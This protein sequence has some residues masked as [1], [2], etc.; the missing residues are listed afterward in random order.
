M[1]IERGTST[2]TIDETQLALLTS[3]RIEGRAGTDTINVESLP[4]GYGGTDGADLLIY[5][6]RLPASSSVAQVP[7]DDPFIDHVNFTGSINLNGGFLDVWADRITVA[8]GT[9][10]NPIIIET[11]NND[12]CFRA[13]LLGIA[14]L[15]N[16]V[17]LGFGTD[18]MVD[19]TIGTYAQLKGYGLWLFSQAEDKSIADTIGATKEIENFVIEPLTGWLGE[20]LALPIK[21]LV[22]NCTANV[23]F[24]EGAQLI[25]TGPIGIYATAAADASS[26]AK[27]SLFSIGYAQAN[28]SADITIETGVLIQAAEAVVITSTGEAKA[29]M[30]VETE[31]KA[32]STPSPGGAGAQFALSLGVSYANIYSHVTM[33]QGATVTAGRTANLTAKGK[34]ESEAEAESGLF[35]DGK[36]GLAFALEF[37]KADVETTV[38]G[39]VIALC[40][41]V[42]G[43]TV[44]IEIDPTVSAA[45]FKSNQT[46]VNLFRGNTVQLVADEDGFA[47][48]TVMKYRG[49]YLESADLSAQVYNSDLWEETTPNIGYV[50]YAND[51]IYVGPNALVT[52]DTVT[53]TRR[54]GVNIGNLVDGREYYVVT[55]GDGWITLTES[56]INALR[57]A[58]GEDWWAVDLFEGMGTANNQKSFTAAEVN[59]A[60]DT[61]TLNRDDPVFNT[62][63]LGQAVVFQAGDGCSI[64]GLTSGNTYYV[65]ASTTEQNIQGDSRFASK[66]IIRLAELENEARA[67]VF[68]D[69]GTATGSDFKLIA[70]HVL[71]SGFAT[72]VG[73]VA[74]LEAE[75][76]CSAKAGLK[77]EDTD[78]PSKWEKFKDFVG[79]NVTDAILQKATESYRTNAAKPGA[80]ASGSIAVSGALAFS[81]ADHDVTTNVGDHAV[82]KSN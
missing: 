43:Y 68:I 16:M 13:R 8:D 48:G 61:I 21:V 69:L 23:T 65:V 75:T 57:V 18:R 52:E 62:F 44:K 26:V 80:G 60:D 63:E 76:K 10:Q 25:A 51:R 22:K 38:D 3:L 19:I 42:G 35:S 20:M 58:A 30:K 39:T 70:K 2:Y 77:S 64:Q 7:M 28:A 53:Y 82:L 36:L 45:D 1:K 66:Q 59:P 46:G 5:G 78:P 33:A 11:V 17:P 55:D 74:T 50:D 29:G 47:A 27:G 49:E 40:D 79:T 14:E 6:S 4:A 15:E 41:P 9:A 37:S 81:Y 32:D 71:D 73:V 56:E 34:I 72:G 24:K 31:H 54:R 12:I 67:G